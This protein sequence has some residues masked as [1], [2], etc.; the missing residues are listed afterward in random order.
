M[1]HTI[2]KQIK[3]AKKNTSY[4]ISLYMQ[5]SERDLVNE[6][7]RTETNIEKNSER[8]RERFLMNNLWTFWLPIRK[9]WK[10][11]VFPARGNKALAYILNKMAWL[12]LSMI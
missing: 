9:K 8:M 1:Q 4:N 7:K 12:N 3:V 2:T 6:S 11:F 10:H 5:Q